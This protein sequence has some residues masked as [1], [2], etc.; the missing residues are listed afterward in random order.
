MLQTIQAIIAALTVLLASAGYTWNDVQLPPVATVT[1]TTTTTTTTVPQ[2]TYRNCPTGTHFRIAGHHVWPDGTPV[3]R[4]A[5]GRP[6]VPSDNLRYV[7]SSCQAHTSDDLAFYTA[8]RACPVKGYPMDIVG[9]G[10][11]WSNCMIAH[12]APVNSKIGD[13]LKNGG[14]VSTPRNS[15]LRGIWCDVD[16]DGKFTD[17][18]RKIT[19]FG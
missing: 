17:A 14:V 10:T 7:R 13:C 8:A 15:Q 12:G 9:S 16:A 1:T 2:Y 5:H 18:D 3:D 4:A 11:T 6:F 19:G